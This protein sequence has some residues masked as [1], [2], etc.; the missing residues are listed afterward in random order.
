MIF[1]NTFEVGLSWH[2]HDAAHIIA[3]KN[4]T[5]NFNGNDRGKSSLF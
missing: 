2:V 4:A 3:T 5:E 1:Y